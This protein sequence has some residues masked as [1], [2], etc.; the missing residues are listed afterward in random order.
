MTKVFGFARSFH[1][2]N[3]YFYQDGGL[4]IWDV[5]VNILVNIISPKRVQYAHSITLLKSEA[6]KCLIVITSIDIQQISSV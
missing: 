2:E 3:L 6:V 1:G 4:K 5:D